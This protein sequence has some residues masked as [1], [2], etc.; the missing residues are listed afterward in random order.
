[1]GSLYS[2]DDPRRD[3]GFSIFYMGINLG[4]FLAPLVC[5]FLAQSE[6]FKGFLGRMGF[7]PEGSWHWGFAMAG[8][9]MTLGLI[10]YIAARKRIAHVGNRPRKTQDSP[11]AELRS[12]AEAQSPA[13]TSQGGT[14]ATMLKGLTWLL[15]AGAAVML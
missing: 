10:Q 5:G 1:V 12:E 2:K 15:W 7:H 8:I 11:S 14:A 4:A 6:W 13:A 9:G 3:A